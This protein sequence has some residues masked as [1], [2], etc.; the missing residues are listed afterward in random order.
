MTEATI[1][2]RKPNEARRWQAFADVVAFALGTNVWISMV[3]LPA[4]FIGALKTR[5]EIAAAALPFGVLMLGLAR[6]SEGVM[7]GL[8]PAAVL[9]P[10]AL[11]PELASSHVY[12]PIR[13]A[14][15]ALGV[16][17]YLFGV[18]FFTSF[19]EPPAP[20]SVRGLSSAQAGPAERWRRRERVYWMLTAMSVVIP[21]VLIAWVNFDTAIADYLGEMYPG[22]VALMTTAL[23]VGAIVLWLGIYHYAFLGVLR[24]HRT[25]DRDLVSTLASARADAKTGKPRSRFY[26]S[27]LLALLAMGALIL[28]RYLGSRGG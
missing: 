15:V 24:P 14:I 13:F 16:I 18:A 10:I 26:L 3:I 27:V 28:L 21:T 20:R 23:T 22:R 8:F 4:I 9:I 2:R 5:G 1:N 6:R 17:A 25:G 19:H 11:N 7:L 12:G